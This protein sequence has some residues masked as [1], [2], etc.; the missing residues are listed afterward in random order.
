M[1]RK[2]Y[3]YMQDFEKSENIEETPELQTGTETILIV[4]DEP[5]ISHLCKSILEMLGY[6]ILTANGQDEAIRLVKEYADRIDLLLTDIVM[7]G[8]NGRELSHRI[9]ALK[10]SIKCLY[11]SGYAEDFIIR[12]RVLEDGVKYVS[13][14]FSIKE[15]A[16]KVRDVLDQ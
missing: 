5:L 2:L 16:D 9:L 8:M 7:P 6:S 4:D 3:N 12:Q 14:P 11:M 10:P 15:L 1:E 13:K